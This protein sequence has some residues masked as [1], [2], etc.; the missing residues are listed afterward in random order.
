MSL[1]LAAVLFVGQCHQFIKRK[2]PK[3]STQIAS[4]RFNTAALLTAF[5]GVLAKTANT[6]LA[7]HH[8]KIGGD[9]YAN[10]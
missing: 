8:T 10:E 2:C 1:S 9:L 6:H 4:S 5:G 7:K 3:V